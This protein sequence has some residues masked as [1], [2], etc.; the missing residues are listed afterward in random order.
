MTGFARRDFLRAVAAAPLLGATLP[1]EPAARSCILIWLTGGPS[2]LDTWDPKPDAPREFRSPFRP[3]RTNVPGIEISEL[4][5]RMAKHADKYALIRSVYGDTAPV[6]EDALRGV[7]ILTAGRAVL[8][9]PLGFLGGAAALRASNP[10]PRSFVENCVGARLLI[11]SGARFVRVNMFNSVFHQPSW[12]SHGTPPFSTVDDY[13][14][15]VAPAFDFAFT[16]FLEDLH[17]R[18]LLESTLVVAMGE[19]GRS[20]RINPAGGRDHWTRCQ[21]VIMA[22]GGVQGGQVYGSSDAIGA[23]PKDKPV[24]TEQVL[25]TIGFAL[26]TPLSVEPVRALFT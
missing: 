8:P 15:V 14:D 3:I 2:H 19:F 24:S 1:A 17:Q 7:D 4:F 25:A 26:G 9:G 5:P 21:T 6:H 12:D 22:G 11:Q 18:G 10:N 20:P 23:E 16:A 13:R